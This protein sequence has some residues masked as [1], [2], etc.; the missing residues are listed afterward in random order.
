MP[1][2][3]SWRVGETLCAV[4]KRNFATHF[5]DF[6]PPGKPDPCGLPLCLG[7]SHHTYPDGDRCPDHAKTPETV[8]GGIILP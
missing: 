2:P 6:I 8:Q 1:A 3:A 5:C 7:C 4:C